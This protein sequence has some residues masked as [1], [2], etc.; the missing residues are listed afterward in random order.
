MR[1]SP[2]QKST[3]TSTEDS[4]RKHSCDTTLPLQGPEQV[5]LHRTGICRKAQDKP[6]LEAA[7]L[8]EKLYITFT[9][10]IQP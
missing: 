1:A 4:Y 5:G 10:I 6:S 9:K 8:L 2:P 3:P 7:S